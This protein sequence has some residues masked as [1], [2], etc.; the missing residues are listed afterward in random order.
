MIYQGEVI[1]SRGFVSHVFFA[2]FT[3]QNLRIMKINVI[4][5]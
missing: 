1:E 3:P 5:K 4:S 2:I